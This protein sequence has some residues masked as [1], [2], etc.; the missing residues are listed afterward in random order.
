MPEL[1]AI[2]AAGA[3]AHERFVS[4]FRAMDKAWREGRLDE[5]VNDMIERAINE[6][7]GSDT[8]AGG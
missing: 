6:H 5:Y 3:A 8:P 4:D 7:S 2:L 1:E